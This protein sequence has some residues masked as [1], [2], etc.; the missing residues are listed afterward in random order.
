MP[1]KNYR[2]DLLGRLAEPEYAAQYLQVAFEETLKD[3]NQAA[4]LLAVENVLAATKLAPTVLDASIA[5]AKIRDLRLEGEG[6]PL[7]TLAAL[8]KTVGLAIEFKPAVTTRQ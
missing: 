5:P 8:L 1:V 7:E 3:G 4:F 2:D 6:L